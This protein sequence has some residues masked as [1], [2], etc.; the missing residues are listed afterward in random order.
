MRRAR[1]W[2]G[3]CARECAV[4]DA[5]R[6]SEPLARAG[7]R[8]RRGPRR[9]RVGSRRRG[10]TRAL[11]LLVFGYGCRRGEGTQVRSV[12][13]RDLPPHPR[14]LEDC[15]HVDP[16]STGCWPLATTTAR[17]PTTSTCT[18]RSSRHPPSPELLTPLLCWRCSRFWRPSPVRAIDTAV[19]LEGRASQAPACR[20]NQVRVPSP[21]Y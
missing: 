13:A 10:A 8:R 21:N 2:I 3:R 5:G 6:R 4:L 18:G 17:S 1:R 16:W 11:S 15:V 9:A 20:R 7:A 12:A 14:L 19:T